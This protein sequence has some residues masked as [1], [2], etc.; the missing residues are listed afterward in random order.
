MGVLLENVPLYQ[1][2][3]EWD[4]SKIPYFIHDKNF[5]VQISVTG[6]NVVIG[7]PIIYGSY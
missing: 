6:E 3:I 1:Y 7:T 5:N 4:S 2:I